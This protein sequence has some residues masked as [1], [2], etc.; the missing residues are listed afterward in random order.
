MIL[1]SGKYL[2]RADL[3]AQALNRADG[4]YSADSLTINV[5]EYERHLTNVLA[6]ASEVWAGPDGRQYILVAEA[7]DSVPSASGKAV[8]QSAIESFAGVVEPY[9]SAALVQIR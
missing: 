9:G 5:A 7:L 8:A 4:I 3:A 2:M 1:H 6:A